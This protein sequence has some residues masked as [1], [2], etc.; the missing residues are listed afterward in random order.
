HR[1]QTF[2]KFFDRT[3]LERRERNTLRQALEV[4][5]E[6]AENPKDWLLFYG[7]HGSGKT[8][9][10]AAI[11]NYRFDQGYPALFITVPDLLDHLRATFSP[12]STTSYDKRFAGIRAAP[13]L[14]LD[15]FGTH[16]ATNWAKEKLY[17][18]LNHRYVARLPTIV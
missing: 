18:L 3:Q 14:V 9:L 8:H 15:D 1:D 17:Q 6:Y 11:A 16:S 10:A 13:F 5:Q 2:A 7:G 4:A 12:T